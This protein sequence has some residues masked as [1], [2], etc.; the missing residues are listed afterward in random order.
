V[1]FVDLRDRADHVTG[2]GFLSC[3]GD[4]AAI[5][6]CL[7]TLSQNLAR[8][9]PGRYRCHNRNQRDGLDR[10]FLEDFA[11]RIFGIE[12]AEFLQ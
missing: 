12:L 1:E 4:H 6:F 9:K 5:S 8:L 10:R 3:F 7:E 11:T 2:F